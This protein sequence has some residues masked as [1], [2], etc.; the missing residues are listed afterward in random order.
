MKISTDNNTHFDLSFLREI[1]GDDYAKEVV[2]LFLEKTPGL[3]EEMRVAVDNEQWED[4]FQKAH[5]LKSSAGL[6]QMA[7]LVRSLEAIEMAAKSQTGL[8][9]IQQ[10]FQDAVMEYSTSSTM[11]RKAVG[12]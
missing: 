11:L 3:L 7:L 5:K 6:L 10:L 9:S 1:D 8:S 4:I 2:A 12:L